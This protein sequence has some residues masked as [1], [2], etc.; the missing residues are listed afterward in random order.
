MKKWQKTKNWQRTWTWIWELPHFKPEVSG[1]GPDPFKGGFFA[2]TNEFPFSQQRQTVNLTWG[3]RPRGS[4]PLKRIPSSSVQ[5]QTNVLT[6]EHSH[7]VRASPVSF[8]SPNLQTSSESFALTQSHVFLLCVR[9][10]MA[11]RLIAR[12][13]LR[14]HEQSVPTLNGEGG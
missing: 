14:A 13:C 11:F 10:T 9:I 12:E 1:Q 5:S 6:R 4:P 7:S 8:I 3:I 2:V